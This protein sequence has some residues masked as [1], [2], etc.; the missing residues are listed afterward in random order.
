MAAVTRS[1]PLE[2]WRRGYLADGPPSGRQQE[3]ALSLTGTV[4]GIAV[5]LAVSWQARAGLLAGAGL[6]TCG[7]GPDQGRAVGQGSRHEVV[8]RTPDR[9][10]RVFVS[11]TLGELAEE[12]RAVLRAVS[13]LRLS[14][15]MFELGAGRTRRGR[16]SSSTWRKAMCSSDCI[17][18]D[19]GSSPGWA[20]LRP[21]GGVRA[22]G[23]AAPPVVCQG[24]SARP[25]CDPAG[26]RP[27]AVLAPSDPLPASRGTPGSR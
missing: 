11:S 22:V 21:G 3:A 15:V 27:A 19:T 25:R 2:W 23:W 17:G 26:G 9:R 12:R 10:L 6:Q 5:G 4:V 16:C 20:G 14:P 24:A 8:I 1:E 13:A 7:V 18:S